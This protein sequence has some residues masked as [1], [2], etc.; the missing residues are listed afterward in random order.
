MGLFGVR[1]AVWLCCAVGEEQPEGL[2]GKCDYF[3]PALGLSYSLP[4][5]LC[6][7]QRLAKGA[8]G[9]LKQFNHSKRLFAGF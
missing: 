4:H 9:E 7:K 1:D 5:S 2:V 6:F 8:L 3:H